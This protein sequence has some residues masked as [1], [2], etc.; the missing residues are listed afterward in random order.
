MSWNSPSTLSAKGK[1][2]LMGTGHTSTNVVAHR[3][4]IEQQSRGVTRHV[5]DFDLEEVLR[6]VRLWQGIHIDAVKNGF[7]QL[8]PR[9]GQLGK[10]VTMP[11]D[12]GYCL[13]TVGACGK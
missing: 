8:R 11:S 12:S 2:E 3:V 9:R 1:L 6:M 5:S 4:A 10:L 13:I 7:F